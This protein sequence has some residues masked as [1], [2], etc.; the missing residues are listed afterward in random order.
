M[1]GLGD[2]LGGIM[3][4]SGAENV[5]A[6]LTKLA[7]PLLDMIQKNG[8]LQALLGQLQNSPIGGQVSSW[9]GGGTNE[10]VSGEQIADAVGPENVEALADQAGM[11]PDQVKGGLSELLPNL[12]DK[13]T[14]GGQIPGA[15][16]LGDIVKQIPGADQA[17]DQLSSIL[18]SLLGGGSR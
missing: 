14:P 4:S 6:D 8:G 17:K 3:G 7:Q 10:P 18:G 2:L 5:R 1:A 11:S 9:I 15:E 12:V 16:Q 13:L